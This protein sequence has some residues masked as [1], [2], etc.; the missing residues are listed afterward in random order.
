MEKITL[1]VN[2]VS[3]LLGISLT[4]IYTMVRENQIPHVKIREKI[5]FNRGVIEAW[6]KGEVESPNEAANT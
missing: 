3:K 6:T 1:D 4:T 5:M 2:E